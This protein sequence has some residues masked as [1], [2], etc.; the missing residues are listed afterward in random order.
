MELPPGALTWTTALKLA[1]QKQP[2]YKVLFMDSLVRKTLP[3]GNIVYYTHPDGPAIQA[4]GGYIYKKEWFGGQQQWG[5]VFS[6]YFHALAYSL[7]L[8]KDNK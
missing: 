8:K 7:K 6:N 4:E 5:W 3:S 2:L 1:K